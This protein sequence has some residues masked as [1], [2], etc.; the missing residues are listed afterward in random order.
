[1][2]N[3]F[4]TQARAGLFPI[5]TLVLPPRIDVETLHRDIEKR[6]LRTVFRA[7]RNNAHPQLTLLLTAAKSQSAIQRAV[8]MIGHALGTQKRT[9]MP[10]IQKP[11]ALQTAESIIL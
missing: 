6:G 11:A 10:A 7:G 9:S 3:A 1:M 8:E 4:V 2:D 5:Q